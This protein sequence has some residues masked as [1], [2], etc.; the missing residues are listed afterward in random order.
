M[1]KILYPFTSLFFIGLS[2]LIVLCTSINITG[3]SFLF[4]VCF[5]F[6][7][8]SWALAI[9]D[10]IIDLLEFLNDL[11]SNVAEEA[12]AVLSKNENNEKSDI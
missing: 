12:E 10:W 4:C 11:Y 2:V 6:K 9:Y 3:A 1:R 7:R 5:V 8:Y